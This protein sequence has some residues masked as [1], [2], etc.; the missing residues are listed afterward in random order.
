MNYFRG[1]F[2]AK[3][4]KNEFSDEICLGVSEWIFERGKKTK[5]LVNKIMKNFF[6]K[7]K[8]SENK[9]GKKFKN[10]IEIVCQ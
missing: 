4:R 1:N 5:K 7:K 2:Q 8:R 6:L 10:L 3:K 9:F